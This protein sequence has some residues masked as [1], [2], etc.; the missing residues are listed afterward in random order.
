[1][2]MG[3]LANAKIAKWIEENETERRRRREM[4]WNWIDKRE[5]ECKEVKEQCGEM[6]QYD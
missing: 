3:W 4:I 2:I 6:K 1:M 5:L